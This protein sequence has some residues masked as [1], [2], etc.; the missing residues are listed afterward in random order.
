MSNMMCLENNIS[1]SES[2]SAVGVAIRGGGVE[3]KTGLFLFMRVIQGP[4]KH[5]S[6]NWSLSAVVC[7]REP[8]SPSVSK[9]EDQKLLKLNFCRVV[10]DG[11]N[12]SAK[13]L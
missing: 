4:W 9:I 7:Q 1:N 2:K 12:G 5:L 8:K 6:L 11:V 13:F 3:L 10:I